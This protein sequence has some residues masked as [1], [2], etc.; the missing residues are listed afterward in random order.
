MEKRLLPLAIYLPRQTRPRHWLVSQINAWIHRKGLSVCLSGTLL[1]QLSANSVE[2]VI[3]K[4]QK[5]TN[6]KISSW[7][8][9]Q[10]SSFGNENWCRVARSQVNLWRLK[11]V[12]DHLHS[13]ALKSLSSPFT[14]SQ[15]IGWKSK[16][17]TWS[18][19]PQRW[20]YFRYLL[21]TSF[22]YLLQTQHL[23]P[24]RQSLPERKVF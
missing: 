11:E 9:F 13:V 8:H 16:R 10:S 21:S 18:W 24:V 7:Y 19:L 12:F 23:S 20:I 3:T 5:L 17:I 4:C 22:M 2:E 15:R 14:L 6:E 1:E